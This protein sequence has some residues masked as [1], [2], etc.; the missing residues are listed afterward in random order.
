MNED[1]ATVVVNVLGEFVDDGEANDIE[2]DDC[3]SVVVRL[4]VVT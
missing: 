3:A 4:V 1:V 2:E